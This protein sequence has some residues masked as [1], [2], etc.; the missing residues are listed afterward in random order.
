[1]PKSSLP[2]PKESR[3]LLEKQ[4]PGCK[5]AGLRATGSWFLVAHFNMPTSD[6]DDRIAVV[7]VPLAGWF[8]GQAGCLPETGNP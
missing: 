8:S 7:A 2:H 6:R 5:L 1:M 3:G 4:R